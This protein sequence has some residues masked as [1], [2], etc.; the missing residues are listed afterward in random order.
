MI[1]EKCGAESKNLSKM[2][3]ELLCRDCLCPDWTPRVNIYR[4]SNLSHA[5]E[6]LTPQFINTPKFLDALR[7]FAAKH[8]LPKDAP[9]N[10]K[11]ER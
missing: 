7:K 1:C 4:S 8:R 6:R 11:F 10:P 2:R 5:E 3:G 9:F